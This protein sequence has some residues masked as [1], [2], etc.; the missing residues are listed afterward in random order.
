[1]P[2]AVS[3]FLGAEAVYLIR[4]DTY[5]VGMAHGH[6]GATNALQPTLISAQSGRFEIDMQRPPPR[7]QILGNHDLQDIELSGVSQPKSS[8]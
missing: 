8:C 4:P 6:E 7:I 2:Q 1:M 3:F 5:V